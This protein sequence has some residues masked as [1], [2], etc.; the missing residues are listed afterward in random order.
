M[1]SSENCSPPAAGSV[2]WNE[3]VTGDTNASADFYGKLFGWKSEPFEPKGRTTGA[4]PY[5]LLKKGNKAEAGMINPMHE[6]APSQWVP[7]VVVDDVHSSLA[8]AES[9]GATTILPVTDI[10]EVGLIAVIKDPK[11]AV[12]GLHQLAK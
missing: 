4:P 6:G 12:I 1:S 11:G 7:Y 5:F 10:G 3:L 8:R 9:L 2:S